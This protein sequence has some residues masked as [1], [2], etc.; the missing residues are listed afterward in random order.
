[1]DNLVQLMKR[2]IPEKRA[3]VV[4]LQKRVN[5]ST[6]IEEQKRKLALLKHEKGWALVI[7]KER[8]CPSFSLLM[9]ESGGASDSGG[10]V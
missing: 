8:V 4:E 3:K 7:G 9:T 6:K 5:A 1:M 2:D 10:R